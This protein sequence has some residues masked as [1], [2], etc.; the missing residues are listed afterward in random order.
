MPPVRHRLPG[1]IFWIRTLM[2]AIVS[3]SAGKRRI[4]AGIQQ[5]E[6]ELLEERLKNDGLIED[7]RYLREELY[8][9]QA[10]NNL[11]H[12][13]DDMNRVSRAGNPHARTTSWACPDMETTLSMPRP[14]TA[15]T[16]PN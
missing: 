5:T 8:R 11:F 14:D 16:C 13:Q 9:V 7:N 12:V 10:D 6:Q 15:A 1:R 3:P 2:I 4:D